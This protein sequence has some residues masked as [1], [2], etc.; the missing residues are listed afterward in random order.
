MENFGRV[1]TATEACPFSG[2]EVQWHPAQDHRN[3]L[4]AA[5]LICQLGA[6]GIWTIRYFLGK[7]DAEP[8]L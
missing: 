4:E 5:R 7:M 1:L 6:L 3:P 8:A 2:P